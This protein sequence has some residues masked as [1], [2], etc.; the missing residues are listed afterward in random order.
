MSDLMHIGTKRHSGRY[1]W[2]SGDQPYQSVDGR[3]F[4][5]YVN[6]LHKEGLSELEIAKDLEINVS[7]LRARKSM[8]KDQEKAANAAMALRLSDKGYS[9]VA[10]GKRMGVN[11]STVRMWLDPAYVERTKITENIS[12]VLKN[13]VA[14]KKYIDVGY[15]VEAH[16]G[17]SQVKL[18]TALRALQDEGYEVKYLTV[19]QVGTGKDTTL[20]ILA[21]P[22]TTASEISKN[23]DQISMVTDTYLIDGGRNIMGIKPIKN[24]NSKRIEVVY[25]NEGGSLKDGVIELRPGVDDISLGNA[26]YAQV[27]IG[28]D[29]THFIKGMAMY[30]ND[31]PEGVDIRFNTSKNRSSDKLDALKPLKEEA[32]NPFGAIVRQ[33]EYIDKNGKEQ[34]SAVNIVNEEGDWTEWT[35]KISPQMLAKQSPA[36]AKKQLE[37]T[38]NLQKEEYDEIMSLTN[39]AVKQ[40]LLTPFSDGADAAAVHLK[41][42]GMPRQAWA[43][44]LPFTDMNSNEVYAPNHRDGESVVLI[45]YPHGGIFE[46]PQLKVNNKHQSAKSLI[47]NAKDAIGINPEVA[48]KL[49]GADFDGDTVLVIPSVN[50]IKTDSTLSGLKNFDPKTSYPKHDGMKVMTEKVKQQEMGKIS[51]LIT[52][53]TIK[54]ASKEEIAAAVRHS[55]VVIDAEKHKLNYKQS[56]IDNGIPA[57]K[58]RYQGESNAGSAT[59]LS[60]AGSPEYVPH[61]SDRTS[62]DPLTGKKIYAPSKRKEY[63]NKQG[64]IVKPLTKTKKMAEVDDAYE[65]S[66]GTQIESI[67]A[68]HANKLK[69][70]AN[71]ARLS[72]LK[73]VP[74]SYSPSA[75]VTYSEQVGTLL[76]KL[77]NAIRN[78]PL[79]RKAQLLAN[80]YI[81]K[82][83]K[84][85]GDLSEGDLKKVKGQALQEARARVGAGKEKIMI[86]PLEW[87]AIQAGAISHTSLLKILDNAD[88]DQV[89]AYATPKVTKIKVSNAKAARAKTMLNAGHTQSEIA[90][91]LG[92]SLTTLQEIIKN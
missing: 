62:I 19:R 44:I 90:D 92:M 76:S 17:I 77:N 58:K 42:A 49:S 25:G 6:T 43:V 45:R 74:R 80:E 5:E 10:I 33:R 7:E 21:P 11:E 41:A 27:R 69:A 56:A 36:L 29:G 22:G 63:V 28:V 57:L 15:G 4:L 50:T 38:Y 86:E 23:R 89:K 65:L 59:L 3:N 87:E 32:S 52:D 61:R 12:Q 13:A 51:N 81:A 31:L 1:P 70:L 46:I 37:K 53:M 66:S 60:K 78:K 14:D 16:L 26:R 72:I 91:A 34:L 85:L 47:G 67:Y 9:N 30:S 18:K 40:K 64:K 20:K 73:I 48:K 68:D 84:K 35:K 75:R 39:P 54:G 83:K 8:Y 88:L 2:G 24:V 82:E 71:Q 79:E 55:M